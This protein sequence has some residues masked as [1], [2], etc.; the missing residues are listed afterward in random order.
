MYIE[1]IINID[2]SMKNI[3]TFLNSKIDMHTQRQ[4]IIRR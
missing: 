4:N 2:I 3:I 1:N